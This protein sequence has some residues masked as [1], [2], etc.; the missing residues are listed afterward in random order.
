MT[1]IHPPHLDTSKNGDLRLT[2]GLT[3]Y[4]GRVEIYWNSEWRTVCNNGWDEHDAKVVCRQL[5]YLSTSV[6]ING[7]YICMN[8]PAYTIQV[9]FQSCLLTQINSNL[10]SVG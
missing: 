9:H 7:A 5:S 4:E 6:H 2:D 3:R 8:K 1:S 10:K